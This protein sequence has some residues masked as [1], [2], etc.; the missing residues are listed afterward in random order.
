MRN[1]RRYDFRI[2]IGGV[3]SGEELEQLRDLGYRTLVD[4][5]DAPEKFGGAVEKRAL[6]IGLDYVS[7]PVDRGEISMDKLSEFYF[8]LYRK[9]SAPLYVFSRFGKRPLAFLLLLDIVRRDEPLLKLFSR[10]SYFGLSL[11]EDE[12]LHEFLVRTYRNLE[13]ERLVTAVCESRPELF[14]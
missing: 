1:A 13:L 14:R 4:T 8:T 2:T 9:D 7:V 6:E 10:A 3:P 11:E 12:A 5:R